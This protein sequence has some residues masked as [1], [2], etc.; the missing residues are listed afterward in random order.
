MVDFGKEHL[1]EM[2]DYVR[3]NDKNGVIQEIYIDLYSPGRNPIGGFDFGRYIN[4][5]PD[6][7]I[8]IS[9][10]EDK[11]RIIGRLISTDRYFY[12]K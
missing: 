11:Q 6:L 3:R 9:F 7:P 2:E 1:P 10:V 8:K 12:V 5:N 4:Q